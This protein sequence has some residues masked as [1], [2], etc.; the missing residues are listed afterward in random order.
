MA[1]VTV[2]ISAPVP[3]DE[4]TSL[5]VTWTDATSSAGNVVHTFLPPFP[6]SDSLL[7]ASDGDS[8]SVTAQFVNVVG[9]S[10]PSNIQ[11][12]VVPT[13]TPPPPTAVPSAPVLSGIT[14]TP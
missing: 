2:Q 6:T 14:A 7:T 8:V 13:P 5:V 4:D 11:T 3:T 10:L 9:S 1:V 12:I